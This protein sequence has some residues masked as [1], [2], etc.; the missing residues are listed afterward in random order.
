MTQKFLFLSLMFFFCAALACGQ[1]E[2]PGSV[3]PIE[4]WI[5]HA[6]LIHEVLPEYPA[7]ARANHIQGNVYITVLVDEN[8][9]IKTASAGNCPACS[10]ILNDAAVQAVKK[11]EYHPTIL[12][13]KPVSVRSYIIFRF[14][15]EK[16]P[17]VEVLTRSE[18]TDPAKPLPAFRPDERR[19]V[20]GGVMSKDSAVKSGL[21]TMPTP[22]TAI[23][24]EWKE[25]VFAD[26]LFKV[27]SPMK[28]T[29]EK[30]THVFMHGESEE[31]RY[32]M[33]SNGLGYIIVYERMQASD[34][35]SPKKILAEMKKSF[36]DSALPNTEKSI[37]LGVYP[38]I[39]MEM[40][41]ATTHYRRRI[42][43]ANRG[44]YLVVATIRKDKPFPEDLKRWDA[45]LTFLE[46][47]K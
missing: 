42:Y 7:S 37:L 3:V 30:R 38:G 19:G 47:K 35:R 44:I 15:L 8:G 9:K 43:V 32:I 23:T 28:P 2:V 39:E 45:S 33:V 22:R 46:P 27:S 31:H 1:E 14:Q 21:I 18:S 11:W 12:N 41:D 29:F 10:L 17:A 20:I 34:H 16:E 25:Y 24:A 5:L 6:K 13:G 36:D 26:D 4:S 40:E